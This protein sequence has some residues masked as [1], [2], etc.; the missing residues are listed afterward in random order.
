MQITI[1]N[2]QKK[3]PVKS[4]K[5]KQVVLKTFK[6]LKINP[7]GQLTILYTD[8]KGIK[9]LNHK[10]LGKNQSTDVLSFDLSEGKKFIADIAISAQKAKTNAGIYN[11][12]AQREMNLYLIHG[13]LHL[14]GYNDYRKSDRIRMQNKAEEILKAI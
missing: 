11:T 1:L 13:I 5:I 4:Q 10:F 12:S 8:N 9:K 14:F 7:S 6:F 2:Q 3:I